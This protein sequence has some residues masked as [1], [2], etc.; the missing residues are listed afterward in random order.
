MQLFLERRFVVEIKRIIYLD[1]LIRKK[2][3]M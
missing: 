2:N 1:K 3:G